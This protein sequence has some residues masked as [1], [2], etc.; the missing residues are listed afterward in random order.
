MTYCPVEPALI[1]STQQG[2]GRNGRKR[3]RTEEG[4]E[5]DKG[6]KR[7][8]QGKREMVCGRAEPV[9]EKI[10]WVRLGRIK[11]GDKWIKIIKIYLIWIARNMEL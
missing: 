8:M 2:T 3:E 7:E 5:E 4:R 9:Q 1:T 10:R 6:S 11:Q